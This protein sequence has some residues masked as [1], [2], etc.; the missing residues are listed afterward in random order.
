MGTALTAPTQL[1]F[2]L[3]IVL[4]AAKCGGQIV[5]ITGCVVGAL[6]TVILKVGH[7][8]SSWIQTG[9]ALTMYLVLSIAILASFRKDPITTVAHRT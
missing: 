1:M 6:G 3:A 5:G 4:Y 2:I 7:A 8:G 9:I